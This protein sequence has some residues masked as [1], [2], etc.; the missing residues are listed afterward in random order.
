MIGEI[1]ITHNQAQ[2]L[3]VLPYVQISGHLEKCCLLL[4]ANESYARAEQDIQVL[5][6]MNVPHSTQQRLVHRH[7]FPEVIV[8]ETVEE[9]SI[10]GGKVRLRSPLGEPCIW[11]DYK[12]IRLHELATGAY[13]KENAALVDWANRQPLATPLF[14]LGDGHD[15]IWNVFEGIGTS[16]QRYEILD[17]Y[18]LKENLYNIPGSLGR[19]KQVEALLWK[20]NV[21][22]AIEAF[23]GCVSS[24][25]VNFVIHLQKHRSRIPNYQY[26]QHE[27]VSIGSGA[28]ESA[29]KQIAR[30][31]KLS[32]AQWDVINV[33]Q[34]LKH[35]CAYLNGY[36]ET[37]PQLN[38]D[39]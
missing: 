2:S 19:I 3:N 29:V 22:A 36:F 17:W 16:E 37:S 15:G 30:R 32:G 35:R 5:T 1:E 27:G 24:E 9:I 10:D 14:G 21:D 28:V 13:F 34:L 23:N 33:P 4:S 12:A 6:G 8:S 25:A 7:E 18:H 20:G 31:V 11:N 26:L 38:D 39:A